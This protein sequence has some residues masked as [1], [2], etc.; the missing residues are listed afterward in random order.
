MWDLWSA[1]AF[2]ASLCVSA[3]CMGWV[4]GCVCWVLQSVVQREANIVTNK[5]M[6]R[7]WPDSMQSAHFPHGECLASCAVSQSARGSAA[8]NQ[9]KGRWMRHSRGAV[10]GQGHVLCVVFAKGPARRC[11]GERCECGGA[12]G[13]TASREI[14]GCFLHASCTPSCQDH[15]RGVC[16][17][18]TRQLIPQEQPLPAGARRR[19]VVGAAGRTRAGFGQQ[20]IKESRF[21][22]LSA[23]KAVQGRDGERQEAKTERKMTVMIMMMMMIISVV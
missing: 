14:P 20:K 4:S 19:S 5:V 13:E 18:A 1:G 22:L 21:H 9:G 12:R 16:K 2:R 8:E 7:A 23:S 17:A 11:S 10:P 15:L 6:V 3:S